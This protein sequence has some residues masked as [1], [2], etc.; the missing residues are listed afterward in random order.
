MDVAFA[1]RFAHL[2]LDLADSNSL[3]GRYVEQVRRGNARPGR[4]DRQDLVDGVSY[5]RISE[6]W[7]RRPTKGRVRG[8]S[9]STTIPSMYCRL[10]HLSR[11]GTIHGGS[12]E[13]QLNI[14]TKD[15]CGC[16]R[17]EPLP[18]ESQR[19]PR[20]AARVSVVRCAP[21]LSS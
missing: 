1:D 13:I 21:G 9:I 5:Q 7:S 16:R 2:R 20:R 4:L 18:Q 19:I 15:V 11:P 3:Y 8:M 6:R 14:V 12:N 17:S 10:F